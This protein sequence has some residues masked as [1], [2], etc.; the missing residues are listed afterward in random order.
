MYNSTV[1]LLDDCK[2]MLKKTYGKFINSKSID[3]NYNEFLSN[4]LFREAR[5]IIIK[6]CEEINE[7]VPSGIKEN[8]NVEEFI[9]FLTSYDGYYSEDVSYISS[10]FNPF[11]DYIELN[12]IELKI[13]NVECNVPR[14]LSYK[15][16]L[17]DVKKCEKRI[18]SEDYSGAITSA[19]SL[20]EGVCKEIILII[21]G[22]EV[23]GSPNFV[24]LFN[25]VRL[26]L[27][28]NPGN[29]ELDSS[30]KQVL[31]GLINIVQGLNEARNKS[32]DSH[33]RKI[34][35][36]LHHAVLVVNSAKTAVN[37]LFHTY[38]Y[39]KKLGKLKPLK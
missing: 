26:H 21:E 27:N 17:E 36:N 28:L 15:H 7:E 3:F 23:T 10:Q 31:N 20:V 1:E 30:L 9:D 38:E 16:I 11:I 34:N 39:Q 18:E 12:R 5:L 25:R 32:G 4:E 8:R 24:K 29:E 2:D 13:I 14:D 37:F 19:K 22:E 35:P 33:A 6:L